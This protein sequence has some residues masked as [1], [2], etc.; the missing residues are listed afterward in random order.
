MAKSSLRMLAFASRSDASRPQL[1]L[2][3]LVTLRHLAEHLDAPCFFKGWDLGGSTLATVE[4]HAC[5]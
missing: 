5:P 4:T 3:G 2:V 1:H